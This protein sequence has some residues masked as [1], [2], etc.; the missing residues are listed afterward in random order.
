MAVC[1]TGFRGGYKGWRRRLAPLSRRHPP[2]ADP[3]M[4][5]VFPT[6]KTAALLARKKCFMQVSP[7]L[8]QSNSAPCRRNLIDLPRNNLKKA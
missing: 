6:A 1:V 2:A 3:A 5:T 4:A 7:N 8:F